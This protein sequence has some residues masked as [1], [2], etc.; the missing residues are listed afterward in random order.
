MVVATAVGDGSRWLVMM[1]VVGGDG[2]HIMLVQ[3][4]TRNKKCI[5]FIYN[6]DGSVSTGYKLQT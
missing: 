2:I 5:L 4:F 6:D 1:D 3:R